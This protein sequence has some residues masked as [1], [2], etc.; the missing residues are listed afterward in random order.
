MGSLVI[1]LEGTRLSVEESELLT[2]P[3]IGGVILFSRNY[4]SRQQLKDL[5]QHIRSVRP[6]PL[7]IMVDQEGGR[8]QRFIHEFTRLPAMATFGELYDNHQKRASRLAKNC[9]WLMA[10]ELLSVHVDL[11]LAPVLDLQKNINQAIGNRAFHPKPEVVIQLGKA[12]IEGM[13]EAGMAATIKHFPGHGSVQL[14]SHLGFPRDERTIQELQ[15]EDMLPFIHLIQDHVEAV[16]VAHILFPNVDAASVSYSRYWLQDI[17]RG[18]L[19]FSG[20]ILSDDLTMEGANISAHY[21]DR[22]IAA[23]EA[24][25]DFT[26]LCNNRKGVIQTIDYLPKHFYFVE[27]K[28]WHRLQGKFTDQLEQQD[29]WQQTNKLISDMYTKRDQ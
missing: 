20:I 15:Q 21:P 13:R 16:M 25:C 22:V 5:C 27:E 8:V 12:F 3:L 4:E 14:D 28:K 23:K 10:V 24:G 2:H 18:K 1:D 17:L 29:R 7:L 6:I 11:S 26:L 9:G 19:G